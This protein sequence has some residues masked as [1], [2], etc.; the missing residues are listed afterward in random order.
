[1]P[2]LAGRDVRLE[3]LQPEHEEAL[4]DASRDPRTWRWLSVVQPATRAEWHAFVMQALEQEA[5]RLELPLVTVH[6]GE[7]VGST[8]F[9]ELR[10][11]HGSVEIGWTWLHPAAW[12]TGANAE[13]KLLQLRH[14]FETWGCRR[15]E[16]KTDAEN[17]RSRAALEAIG[18][19]FEGVH[20]K[21][22]LVRA[23]ENRDSAWYSVTDD[24][25]PAV[26]SLLE[27]RLERWAGER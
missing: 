4:W 1:M 17:A 18:A 19:S 22:M 27:R 21:H 3:P 12:G 23:G 2:V 13:A 7:V 5:A 8:R 10:P 25:W 9:L 20:R 14:A 6:D 11:Q 16:F 24:D 26:E 15:V